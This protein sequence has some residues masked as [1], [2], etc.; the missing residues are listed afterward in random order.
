MVHQKD[1]RKEINIGVDFFWNNPTKPWRKK[2]YEVMCHK[3][4]VF[5]FGKIKVGESLSKQENDISRGTP[6]LR[7]LQVQPNDLSRFTS[8]SGQTWK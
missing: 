4:E 8:Q 1:L 2:I 3:K 6:K 5:D 7:N